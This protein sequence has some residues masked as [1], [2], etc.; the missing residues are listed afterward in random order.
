MYGFI[1]SPVDERG[2]S[3]SRTARSRH[4]STTFSIPITVTRVCGSVV[5]MRPFP[6]DSTTHTVPVSATA[7]F[8][9]EIAT[10]AR[11]N[12]S[13]RYGPRRRGQRRRVVGQ[14]GLVERLPQE[15]GDLAPAAV[16]GGDEEVRRPLSGELHDQLGEVGLDRPDPGLE[17]APR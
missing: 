13:R 8:A 16:D 5:H 4:S 6:S 1:R 15:L 3:W 14:V 7:A 12:A 11:R 17:R 2:R 10:V 9:P